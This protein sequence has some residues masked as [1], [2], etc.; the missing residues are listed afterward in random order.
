MKTLYLTR[1]NNIVIDQEENTVDKLSSA[2]QGIDYIYLVKEPMHVVYGYG[3]QQQEFDVKKNEIIVVFYTNVFKNKV[4]VVKNKQWAD[5]LL[6]Y[7]KKEQE[8]KEAW[9]A[10]NIA[11]SCDSAC[12]NCESKSC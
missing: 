7:E 1:G 3:D 12:V 2:R 5:N 10:K 4:V 8:Q 6:E 9:A 11:E